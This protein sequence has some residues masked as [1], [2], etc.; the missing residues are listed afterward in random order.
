[1]NRFTF[2]HCAG[3]ISTAA[4]TVCAV[5]AFYADSILM[6]MKLAFASVCAFALSVL[7]EACDD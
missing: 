2:W 1:M 3:L 7:S 5:Q 6:F 4:G